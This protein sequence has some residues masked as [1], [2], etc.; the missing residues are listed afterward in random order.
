MVLN[1]PKLE[2][3]GIFTIIRKI[4]PVKVEMQRWIFIP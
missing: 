1:F 3:W 2:I 4:P